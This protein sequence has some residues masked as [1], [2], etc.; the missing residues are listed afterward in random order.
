MLVATS[1]K[2]MLWT[3]SLNLQWCFYG[4]LNTSNRFVACLLVLVELMN[5]NV[6]EAV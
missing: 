5:F 4:A 3:N 2:V 1:F 6:Q